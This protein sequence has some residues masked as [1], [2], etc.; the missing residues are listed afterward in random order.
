MAVFKGNLDFCQIQQFYFY[1]WE[2]GFE[3]SKL[4]KLIPD[5]PHHVKYFKRLQDNFVI[6]V[7]KRCYIIRFTKQLQVF[8][9]FLVVRVHVRKFRCLSILNPIFNSILNPYRN[10]AQS[11]D[12]NKQ[13]QPAGKQINP[14]HSNKMAHVY[15]YIYIHIYIEREPF[16]IVPKCITINVISIQQRIQR[17]IK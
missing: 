13:A 2:T 5:H 16:E 6:L 12:G 17:H 7:N 10:P 4:S 3:K 1:F 8:L 11:G 15:I 14:S 9:Y